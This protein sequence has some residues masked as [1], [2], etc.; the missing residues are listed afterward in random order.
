MTTRADDLRAAAR[1]IDDSCGEKSEIG[2]GLR[3]HADAI[4]EQ[5][6]E[7]ERLRTACSKLNDGVSQTLG[8]VLDYP[9]FKDDQKNFPGATEA[10]GVCVGEHVAETIAM[11]AAREIERLRARVA[12]LEAGEPVAWIYT[13]SD[14]TESEYRLTT[15]RWEPYAVV[16]WQ[17]RPLFLGPQRMT[18]DW[19]KT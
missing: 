19:G 7:L 1:W 2:D 14:E 13:R 18:P 16:G 12:E 4:A 3:Q 10:N 9:W 17:E 6:A 8:K 15:H 5:D 11:E